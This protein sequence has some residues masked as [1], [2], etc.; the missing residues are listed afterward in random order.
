MAIIKMISY[1]Q[2]FQVLCN[3]DND[4]SGRLDAGKLRVLFYFGVIGT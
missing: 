2:K 1:Q 4:L 3:A